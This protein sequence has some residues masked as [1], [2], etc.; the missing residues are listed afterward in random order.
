MRYSFSPQNW[1]GGIF[2]NHFPIL[3]HVARTCD[4]DIIIIEPCA[5][6]ST[7]TPATNLTLNNRNRTFVQTKSI[8]S[9][10][11]AYDYE[12][13]VRTGLRII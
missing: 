8:Y 9:F 6:Q 1:F 13:E 11:T 7:F 4:L 2:V 12:V 3:P 5:E 10:L